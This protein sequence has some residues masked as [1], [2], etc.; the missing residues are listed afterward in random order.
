[1]RMSTNSFCCLSVLHSWLTCWLNYSCTLLCSIARDKAY[2][3]QNLLVTHAQ[4][5]N[6]ESPS[7]AKYLHHFQISNVKR[8]G[9]DLFAKES[10]ETVL[11]KNLHDSAST[12]F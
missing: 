11:K 8:N 7:I 12:S 1:M 4:S 10:V 2:S 6:M 3:C 5:S 9:N